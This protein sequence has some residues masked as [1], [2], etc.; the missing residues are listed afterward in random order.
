MNVSIKKKN[1]KS[2]LVIEVDIPKEPPLSKS[3]KSFLIA[4]SG[5]YAQTTAKWNDKPVY[6]GLNAGCYVKDK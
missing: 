5:G 3:G 6:V 2:V 1:G 4:S